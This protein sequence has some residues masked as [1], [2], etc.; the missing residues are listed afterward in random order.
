MLA[1]CGQSWGYLAGPSGH[2]LIK[3]SAL[4][5]LDL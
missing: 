3:E 2:L 1:I 5:C 4:C